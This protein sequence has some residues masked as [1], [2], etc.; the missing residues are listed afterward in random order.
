MCHSM[1]SVTFDL[2]HVLCAVSCMV[3]SDLW[4]AFTGPSIVLPCLLFI[5]VRAVLATL[6]FMR[7]EFGFEVWVR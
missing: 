6:R 4:Y 3:R 2:A 1:M 5:F 7:F